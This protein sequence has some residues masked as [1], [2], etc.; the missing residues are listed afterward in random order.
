MVKASGTTTRSR[1]RTEEPARASGIA[2]EDLQKAL[3]GARPKV[4]ALIVLAAFCGLRSQ[5]MADLEWT[6]LRVSDGQP[7][8]LVRGKHARMVPVPQIVLIALED[9]GRRPSGPV[10]PRMDGQGPQPAQYLRYAIRIHLARTPL[11]GLA[12]HLHRF[13]GSREYRQVMADFHVAEA[14]IGHGTLPGTPRCP[15]C[16]SRTPSP[17]EYLGRRPTVNDLGLLRPP[18]RW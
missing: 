7:V 2:R 14:M 1:P 12:G 15:T 6:D 17:G 5:E 13:H 8:L 4:R 11:A 10:F 16:G 3:K 18:P 9:H